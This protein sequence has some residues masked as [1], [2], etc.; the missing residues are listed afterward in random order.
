MPKT[1]SPGTVWAAKPPAGVVFSCVEC[2]GSFITEENEPTAHQDQLT[3]EG[4]GDVRGWR[5]DSPTDGCLAKCWI[6]IGAKQYQDELHA[7][8]AVNA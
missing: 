6:G 5:I 7:K 4:S 3:K 1:L 8:A 2:G